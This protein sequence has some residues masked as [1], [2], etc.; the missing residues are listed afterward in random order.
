MT[1][2]SQ[3]FIPTLR[4]E[5]AESDLALRLLIRAGYIRRVPGG[6]AYLPLA[7]RML[8]KIVQI[9][10]EEMDAI[11]GQEFHVKRSDLSS[12]T[13]ELKSYK[14]VQQI[15]YWFEDGLESFSIDLPEEKACQLH[16]SAF[17]RILKRC[18]VS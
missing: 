6:F 5:P 2:W 11:G 10:R 4:D 9:A 14:Q 7:R 12:I 3:S 15:W 16:E 18:A 17:R 8:R 1:L 13:S